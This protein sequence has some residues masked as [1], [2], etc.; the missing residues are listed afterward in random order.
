MSLM[1]HALQSAEACRLAFPGEPHMALAGLLHGL[2]KLLAHA[3]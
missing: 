3:K 2:G 1:E